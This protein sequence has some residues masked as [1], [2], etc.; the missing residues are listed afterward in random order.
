[1]FPSDL[2]AVETLQYLG[3]QIV[4]LRRQLAHTM[5]YTKL[6]ARAAKGADLMSKNQIIST[7]GLARQTV[8]DMFK[9]E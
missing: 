1:V 6:A 8:L 9:D 7:T 4:L 3:E 2:E 5:R